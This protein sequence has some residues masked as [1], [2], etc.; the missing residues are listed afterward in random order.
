MKRSTN[1]NPRHFHPTAADLAN[2]MDFVG[3]TLMEKRVAVARQMAA[4][5]TY[6]PAAR[7]AEE[8]ITVRY[9]QSLSTVLAARGWRHES[10]GQPGKQRVY[11]DTGAVVGDLTVFECWFVVLLMDE[12]APDGADLDP[13]DLPF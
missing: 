5:R 7:E 11:D 10:A 4:R 8:R 12:S 1:F 9:Q 2:L 3:M 13:D 6:D